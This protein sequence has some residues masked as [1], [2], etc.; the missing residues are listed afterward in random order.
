MKNIKNTAAAFGMMA[1][2]GL[3]AVTA[4]A[5]MILSDRSVGST[6]TCGANTGGIFSQVAGIL[7]V[8]ASSSLTGILMSDRSGMILSDRNAGGCQATQSRDGILMSD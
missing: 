3:G 7:I 4:N 2:L 1:V 6:P 5:G 8:G